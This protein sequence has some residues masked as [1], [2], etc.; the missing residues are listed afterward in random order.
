MSQPIATI[1]IP[2]YNGMKYLPELLSSL[3]RQSDLRFVITIVDD[4]STDESAAYTRGSWPEVRLIVNETNLGF[5]GTCNAGMQ[6]ARTPFV[7]LLN[8]DTHVDEQWFAEGIRAFGSG[9]ESNE[10][11]E[12]SGD[13]GSVASLVLLAEPPNLIDTA[14]DAYSV[15]GGA[16][17]RNHLLPRETA[18]TLPRDCFSASGASAFYRR[19]GVERAGY[20]D[21][22]FESYYEDV[23]LGFRL[24]WA[25]YRC[26]FAARSI[27]YHHLSSSYS[28]K[29]W[30][31]H[32]NSARNSE[33]VWRANM[34]EFL[35]KRYASSRR[36]FLAMQAA[37]KLRQGCLRAW[38]A[39]KRA[40]R[41]AGQLIEEKRS[42]LPLSDA[43]AA[44]RVASMLEKDWLALH[45][46]SGSR[47]RR[48]CVQA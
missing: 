25:G 29:G 16:M 6:A 40:A 17:K 20:L 32:F 23:D 9:G 12:G 28:P 34:P 11:G 27:C 38:L 43:V 3:R 8:N 13:V 30:K 14:G 2:N 19:E 10:I 18:E 4:Q 5:A 41:L 45:V 15:V 47:S 46:G 35:I 39:G 31:Y 1:I 44:Q 37:N 24:A 22:R 42:R 7:V 26:R 36:L 21:E 48:R 33:I